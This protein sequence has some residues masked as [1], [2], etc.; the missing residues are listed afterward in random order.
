MDVL[1]ARVLVRRKGRAVSRRGIKSIFLAGLLLAFGVASF[2]ASAAISMA[3]LSTDQRLQTEAML[4][5]QIQRLVDVQRRV[6]GQ[7]KFVKV[8]VRLD[9]SRG[10]VLIDLSPNYLPSQIGPHFDDLADELAD[11]AVFLLRDSITVH[12]VL[13]TY[14]GKDIYDYFPEDKPESPPSKSASSLGSRGDLLIFP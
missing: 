5:Q 7:G 8:Q 6:E 2:T 3:Q 4:T 12:G 1:F 14:G 11:E 9:Q 13:F 10:F